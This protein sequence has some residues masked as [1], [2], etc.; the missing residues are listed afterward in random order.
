MISAETAA[1]SRIGHVFVGQHE[2]D[3]IGIVG[4]ALTLDGIGYDFLNRA[5][6]AERFPQRIVVVIVLLCGVTHGVQDELASAVTVSRVDLFLA[7]S[8]EMLKVVVDDP[9]VFG[10]PVT[11]PDDV[12]GRR[13][14]KYRSTV[15]VNVAGG[16]IAV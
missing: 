7:G 14:F 2:V 11:V 13:F 5:I 3:A 6:A 16:A 8:T 12:N 9:F 15:V 4:E 1:E 10:A